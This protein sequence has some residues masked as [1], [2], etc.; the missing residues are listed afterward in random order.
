MKRFLDPKHQLLSKEVLEETV[1]GIQY[2]EV[3]LNEKKTGKGTLI[4]WISQTTIV[5][6]MNQEN[7]RLNS[8]FEANG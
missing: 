2:A 4:C 5:P 8:M 1:C 7:M 6:S 3:L